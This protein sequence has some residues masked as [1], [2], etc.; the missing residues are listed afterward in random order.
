MYREKVEGALFCKAKKLEDSL[1]FNFRDFKFKMPL[2][3]NQVEMSTDCIC[4]LVFI[5][6]LSVG[7]V[8]KSLE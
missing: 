4:G 5:R 3:I 1:L 2:Q 6:D 8:L 7:Y